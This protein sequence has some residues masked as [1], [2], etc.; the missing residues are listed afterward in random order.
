M[1]PVSL[2]ACSSTDVWL[3]LTAL[4]VV[5]GRET[6][7]DPVG[8]SAGLRGGVESTFSRER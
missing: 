3:K 1:G 7:A 6:E 8:H 2:V 4:M 5:F